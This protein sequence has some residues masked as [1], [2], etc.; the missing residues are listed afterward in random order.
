MVSMVTDRA[1]A[2]VQLPYC[3]SAQSCLSC[4][5]PL[6]SKRKLLPLFLRSPIIFSLC[7][8]HARRCPWRGVHAPTCRLSRDAEHGAFLTVFGISRRRRVDWKRGAQKQP[9][10]L[11]VGAWKRERPTIRTKQWGPGLRTS[12]RA[13]VEG[14]EW[15][16]REPES[17]GRTWLLG[18][19]A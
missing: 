12:E 11:R 19:Q 2:R 5:A 15:A 9:T 8:V 18:G 7:L 3:A 4:P 13:P 14:E 1:A 10:P 17:E 6:V 16:G